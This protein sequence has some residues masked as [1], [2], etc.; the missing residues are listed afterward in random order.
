MYTTI[1][2]LCPKYMPLHIN[3]Q[4]SATIEI[5]DSAVL[6]RQCFTDGKTLKRRVSD[7]GVNFNVNTKT[8]ACDLSRH[9]DG[10]GS[11]FEVQFIPNS[12]PHK[13][14]ASKELRITAKACES[15]HWSELTP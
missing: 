14:E 8:A 2:V 3:S 7:C 4:R 5:A 11:R 1:I 10:G 6:M 9:Q 12:E 13:L 15:A